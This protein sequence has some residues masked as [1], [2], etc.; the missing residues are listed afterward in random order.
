MQQQLNLELSIEETN[1]ILKAVSQ[2]P[3]YQVHELISKIQQ[4]TYPQL[5][6]LQKE[7][8]EEA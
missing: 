3:Y 4:Q 1:L 7:K 8:K 6:D 2:L 5:Q